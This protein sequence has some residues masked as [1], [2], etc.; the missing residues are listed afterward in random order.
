MTLELGSMYNPLTKSEQAYE[1]LWADYSAS[2]VDGQRWSIVIDLDDPEHKAKGRVVRVGEH[3]QAI[4]RVGEQV[5]IERWKFDTSEKEG[6]GAW[7]RFARLGDMFLPVSLTFTPERVA[8]GNTLTFE[9]Y[10]W[11]VKEVYSW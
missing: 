9:D 2:P 11:E 1:E 10:K 3:C 7:K 5:T 4:L 6:K 8:E